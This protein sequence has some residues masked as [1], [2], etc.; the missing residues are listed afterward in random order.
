MLFHKASPAAA[1][2]E[3]EEDN[4]GPINLNKW[5]EVKEVLKEILHQF[6]MYP[7]L[8]EDDH[9]GRLK[10]IKTVKTASIDMKKNNMTPLGEGPNI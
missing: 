3:D 10:F 9:L 5:K 6:T 7:K 2:P 1:C 8:G 4:R